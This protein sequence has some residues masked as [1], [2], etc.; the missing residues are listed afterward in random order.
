MQTASIRWVSEQQF[1]GISPSSHTTTMDADGKSNKAPTPMELLLIAL[2]GCTASDMVSI[3]E[4]KRQKLQSLVVECSGERA[5]EPPRVWTKIDVV[6]RLRGLLDETAV[7][8]ALQLTKDK[9]CS[10]SAML[11]ETAKITWHYEISP[12]E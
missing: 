1:L 9:Y 3:L 4:K 6:F 2:G 11:E 12:P 5:A 10:V 7:K 8:H